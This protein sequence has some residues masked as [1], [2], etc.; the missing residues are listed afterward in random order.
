[1]SQLLFKSF[2]LGFVCLAVVMQLTS[3]SVWSSTK[4]RVQVVAS[5]VPAL[6][7]PTVSVRHNELPISSGTTKEE[8]RQFALQHLSD[9]SLAEAVQALTELSVYD[10][11]FWMTSSN[12]HLKLLRVSKDHARIVI[13]A[14]DASVTLPTFQNAVEV[15]RKKTKFGFNAGKTC[16]I[17]YHNRS[18]TAGELAAIQSALRSSIAADP[19]WVGLL[20]HQ[21]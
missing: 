17:E 1:M 15:C 6:G 11:E 20:T 2:L 7:T 3:A 14:A 9:P 18:P 10:D 4:T 16:H 19:K 5:P 21:S 8:I 12:A 13:A